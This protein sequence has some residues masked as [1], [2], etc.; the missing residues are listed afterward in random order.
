[1]DLKLMHDFILVKEVI[2]NNTIEGTNLSIKYDDSDRFMYAEIVAVS[3]ELALEY[4]KYYPLIQTESLSAIRYLINTNYK[5]GTK[6]VLQRI[7]K[8][9]FKDGLYFASFKDIIA[10]IP[11]KKE[12]DNA[13]SFKDMPE[14]KLMQ[15]KLFG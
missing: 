9:P 13:E 5:P 11:D 7:A 15:E 1:M 2:M 12:T 10:I 6:V 3:E 14:V 8:V 4:A